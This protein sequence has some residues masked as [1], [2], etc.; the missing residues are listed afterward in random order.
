MNF[1]QDFELPVHEGFQVGVSK[2]SNQRFSSDSPRHWG[3]NIPALKGKTTRSKTI[4]VARDYVKVTL[5]L[6][7]L[8]KE[9][10]LMTDV[11]FVNKN[12]LFLTL[13]R[14]ITFAAVNHLADRRVPYTFKAFKEICQYS[15]QRGFDITVVHADGEFAPLK[16]LIESI[17]G[18]PV[19]NLAST[20]EHV[21]EID[22]RNTVGPLGT[23][24][25][26]SVTPRLRKYTFCSMW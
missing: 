4:P 13:S 11:F 17:P 10:F 25:H 9:V 18:G 15:L 19:V 20:N 12:T 8:H 16:P 24:F 21:P 22:H 14:K 1:V 26:L 6:M 3:N 2:Q 5:E 23:A 7:K